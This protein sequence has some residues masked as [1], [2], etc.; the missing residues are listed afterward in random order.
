[1][2]KIEN[3]IYFIDIINMTELDRD[4]ICQLMDAGKNVQEISIKLHLSIEIIKAYVRDNGLDERLKNKSCFFWLPKEDEQLV[5]EIEQGM[6]LFDI[7]RAHRRSEK[8]I[9]DHV[10]KVL[11]MD[12]PYLFAQKRNPKDWR[13][14]DVELLIQMVKQQRSLRD[15]SQHF[16]RKPKAIKGKY[17]KLRKERPGLPPLGKMSKRPPGAVHPAKQKKLAQMLSATSSTEQS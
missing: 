14:A 7:A 12:V 11:K 15:I 16:G 4:R 1:M 10:K 6:S 5:Q 2:A 13:E 9:I 3:E 8:A 17:A